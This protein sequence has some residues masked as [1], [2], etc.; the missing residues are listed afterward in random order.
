MSSKSS[1]LKILRRLL[2]VYILQEVVNY[3]FSSL[4]EHLEMVTP[5]AEDVVTQIVIDVCALEEALSSYTSL[6][7]KY[8]CHFSF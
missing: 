5:D 7:T 8:F 3:A 6:E 2:Y 1:K 4:L